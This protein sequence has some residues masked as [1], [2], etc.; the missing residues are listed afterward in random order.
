[1]SN[2]YALVIREGACVAADVFSTRELA[3]QAGADYCLNLWENGSYDNLSNEEIIEKVVEENPDVW[4]WIV[5]RTID[6]DSQK[7]IN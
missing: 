6:T 5:E 7:F 1:M 4:V 3:A 2:V